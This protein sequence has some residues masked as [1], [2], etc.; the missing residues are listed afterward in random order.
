VLVEVVV[1][2]AELWTMDD[3]C[4]RLFMASV[5]RLYIAQDPR[6]TKN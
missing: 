2:D 4:C 6:K 1:V 3:G 5:K